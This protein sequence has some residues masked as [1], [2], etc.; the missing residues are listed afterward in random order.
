MVHICLNSYNLTAFSRDNCYMNF[1]WQ[2]THVSKEVKFEALLLAFYSYRQI[3]CNVIFLYL[4]MS[5]SLI[6]GFWILGFRFLSF[7]VALLKDSSH[8]SIALMSMLWLLCYSPCMDS[9]LSNVSLARIALLCALVGA[10]LIK[11]RSSKD[12]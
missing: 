5:F 9:S 4:K 10:R 12:G 3:Q 7:G 11:V 2:R 1:N 6:C 8:A